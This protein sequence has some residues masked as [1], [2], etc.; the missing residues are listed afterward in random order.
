MAKVDPYNT[1]SPEYGP[2]HREVYHDHD[3]CKYGK[4]IQEK[5]RQNGKG[6]KAR[7]DE[8]QKLG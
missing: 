5:H 3:D 1:D 7:C 8:C 6:G 2:K 4:E